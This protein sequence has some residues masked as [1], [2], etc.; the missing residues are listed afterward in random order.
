MNLSI[1]TILITVS[2]TIVV[3]LPLLNSNVYAVTVNKSFFSVNVSDNWAYLNVKFKDGADY[4][5]SI[6]LIPTEFSD[7]LIN[8]DK[9]DPQ[10]LFQ[11]VGASSFLTLDSAYLFRNVPLEIYAQSQMNQ[12][13]DEIL[14]KENSTIDG[15]KALKIHK[16]ARNNL[17]DI[18]ELMTYYVIHDGNPYYLKY[19]A[20]VKDFPKYLPQ[21]EQMVKTFKFAG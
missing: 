1:F 14:S 2:M 16:I 12:S 18:Y 6:L 7:F 17:T 9:R 5:S 15:E 20:K 19:Y 8:L 11:N 21:F 3:L 13:S 4:N 10:E